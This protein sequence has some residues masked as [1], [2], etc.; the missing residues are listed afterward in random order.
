IEQ[1]APELSIV[2][3]VVF[4]WIFI[5]ADIVCIVLQA[6]GGAISTVSYGA[7]ETGV[8]VALAGLATQV[9]FLFGFCICFVHYMVRYFQSRS[10]PPMS[11]KLQKCFGF[12]ALAVLCILGRCCYRCYELS[13]G[14][15]HS[16]VITNEGLFIGLEGVLVLIAVF[17]LIISHPGR[18]FRPAHQTPPGPVSPPLAK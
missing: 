8:K 14:Y 18:M 12:L 1:L 11:P 13:Q 10:T 7:S 17:A 3:P 15:R 9:I 4:Y 2:T 16:T 5:T 6:S